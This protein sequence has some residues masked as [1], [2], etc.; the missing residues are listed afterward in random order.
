MASTGSYVNH[1]HLAT[2]QTDNHASTPSMNFL[3]IGCSSWRP[4]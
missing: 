3:Q 4:T 1:L 2:L